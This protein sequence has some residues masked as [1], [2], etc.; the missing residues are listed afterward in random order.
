MAVW[1]KVERRSPFSSISC[2]TSAVDDS[3]RPEPRTRLARQSR[4]N[5]NGGKLSTAAQASTCARPRPKIVPRR[6]H[7]RAGRNSSPITKRNSTTPNSAKCISSSGCS[8]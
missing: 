8:A 1:P 4:P 2:I 5:R 6:A 3:A 7:R